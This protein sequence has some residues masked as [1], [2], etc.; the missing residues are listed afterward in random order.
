MISSSQLN[1]FELLYYN[2]IKLHTQ[3]SQ[4]MYQFESLLLDPSYLV[5]VP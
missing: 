5:K 3:E 1:N 4:N 2:N